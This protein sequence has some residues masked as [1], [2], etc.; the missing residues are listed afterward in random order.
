MKVIY[1]FTSQKS[2]NILVLH[3]LYP[4]NGKIILRIFMHDFSLIKV[5]WGNVSFFMKP[6]YPNNKLRKNIAQKLENKG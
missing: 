5:F 6:N 1:K 3:R 4:K 2:D